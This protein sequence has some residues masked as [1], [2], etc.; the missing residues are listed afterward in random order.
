MKRFVTMID[1]PAGWKYGFPKPLPKQFDTYE[2][3]EA[4]LLSEGYPKREIE[5]CGNH[6]YCKYF[7]TEVET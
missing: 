2:E 6:F 4:W 7:V 1:P 5:L 3:L